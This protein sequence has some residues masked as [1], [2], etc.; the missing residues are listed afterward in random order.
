MSDEVHGLFLNELSFVPTAVEN[1]DALLKVK[2]FPVGIDLE[3]LNQAG[4][5]R[6]CLS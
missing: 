4:A 5:P 1:E 2:S 6:S 3:G